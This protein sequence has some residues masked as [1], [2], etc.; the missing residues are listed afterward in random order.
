[1]QVAGPN[2]CE[3]NPSHLGHV[4]HDETMTSMEGERFVVFGDGKP[5]EILLF[6]GF[7]VVMNIL[8]SICWCIISIYESYHSPT[9]P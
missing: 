4:T 3:S 6:S 5:V 1:M 8:F 7:C 2:G 9:S